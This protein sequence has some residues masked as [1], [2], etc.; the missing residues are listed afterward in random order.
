[1]SERAL[2]KSKPGRKPRFTPEQLRA[3]TLGAAV[4][5]VLKHGVAGGVD[6]VRIE[7]VIIEA[8]VPR[9]PAYELW[10]K[11]GTGTPQQNLRRAAILHFLR[12]LPASNFASIREMTMSVLGEKSE[13]LNS[14]RREEIDELRSEL[15]R[16]ICEHSF[17]RFQTQDWRV[18]RALMTS[19][20][21]RDDPELRDAVAEGESR[22]LRAYAALFDDL[23]EALRLRPRKPFSTKDFT[24]AVY[25]LE[26]GLSNR[27]TFAG[28]SGRDAPL[29]IDGA[30]WSLFAAAMHGLSLHFFEPA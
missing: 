29:V 10:D 5:S 24:V 4:D 11:E 3:R 30:E 18:F 17:E 22:L 15:A 7:H 1:M 27:V 9:A 8:D 26:Q 2:T 28:D 21:T 19:I 13:I 14:G 16:T 25:A 6:S 23:A 20:G 12:D